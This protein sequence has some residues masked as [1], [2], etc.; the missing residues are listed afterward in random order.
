MAQMTMT[1]TWLGLFQELILTVCIDSQLYT[2]KHMK[3]L[4]PTKT[5]NVRRLITIN[6]LTFPDYQMLTAIA[7]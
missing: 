3:Q 1:Q 2:V 7:L 6:C 5:E 4:S